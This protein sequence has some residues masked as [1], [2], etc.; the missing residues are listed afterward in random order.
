MKSN[1]TE[2]MDSNQS[3]SFFSFGNINSAGCITQTSTVQSNQSDT[4]NLNELWGRKK[5]MQSIDY[6]QCIGHKAAR[7][8]K[9][10]SGVE[11]SS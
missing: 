6:P 7:V 1:Q 5:E 3:T 10:F 8:V 11:S 9:V 4:G 2:N